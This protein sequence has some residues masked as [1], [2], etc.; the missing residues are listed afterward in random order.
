[1][2]SSFFLFTACPG[3][4]GNQNVI[5][6]ELTVS[7]RSKFKFLSDFCRFLVGFTV[8]GKTNKKPKKIPQ[9]KICCG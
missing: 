4:G 7:V 8:N 1:M 6:V 2:A 9:K 5:W 3:R